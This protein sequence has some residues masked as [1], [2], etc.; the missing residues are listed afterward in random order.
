MFFL[1][2][3]ETAAQTQTALKKLEMTSSISSVTSE[4]ME[5]RPPRSRMQFGMNFVVYF[6]V[7]TRV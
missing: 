1:F 4:D 3:R 2:Y 7:N 6:P 5:N